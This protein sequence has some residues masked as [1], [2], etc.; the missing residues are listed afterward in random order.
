MEHLAH[1]FPV[2]TELVFE[3][4]ISSLPEFIRGRNA[5]FVINRPTELSGRNICMF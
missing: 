3:S 5:H 4:N 2:R 1:C